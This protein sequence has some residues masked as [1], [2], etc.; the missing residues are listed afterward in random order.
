M[1]F[2]LKSVSVFYN[3]SDSISKTTFK[4][5]FGI[6]CCFECILLNAKHNSHKHF[7]Y[8]FFRWIK[9]ILP[10]FFLWNNDLTTLVDCEKKQTCTNRHI[11][12]KTALAIYLLFIQQQSKPCQI[13]VNCISDKQN[14]KTNPKHFEK[15]KIERLLSQIT[16]KRDYHSKSK[17]K[18]G[19]KNFM[20]SKM[21]PCNKH[22]KERWT[23]HKGQL[24]PNNCL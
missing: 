8:Q 22:S 4:L 12:G 20:Q 13:L 1:I 15:T 17:K 14:R 21:L 19:G 18:N 16:N 6:V 23:P 5:G 24:I 10:M 7:I 3:F 9:P 11:V 2:L